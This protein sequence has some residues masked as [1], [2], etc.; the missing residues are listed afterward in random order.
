ME[1]L[2]A[3]LEETRKVEAVLRKELLVAKNELEKLRGQDM[4][5]VKALEEAQDKSE[6]FLTKVSCL[7]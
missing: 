7:R 1:D 3:R 5:N 6:R 4:E 2:E